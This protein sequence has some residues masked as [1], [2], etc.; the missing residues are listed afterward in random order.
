MT[1]TRYETSIDYR[2]GYD[3][4]R[5]HGRD[6]IF[7]FIIQELWEMAT[8]DVDSPGSKDL[9]AAHDYFKKAQREFD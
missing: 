9:L 1:E 3:L 6:E 7:A 2:D 5:H 8:F 4:G